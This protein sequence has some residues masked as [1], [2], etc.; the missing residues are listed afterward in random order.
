MKKLVILSLLLTVVIRLN[1]Q[2]LGIEEQSV[3]PYKQITRKKTEPT[4]PLNESSS[5]IGD[6][7]NID[8]LP[9]N[10]DNIKED[11]EPVLETIRELAGSASAQTSADQTTVESSEST[12]PPPEIIPEVSAP[13]AEQAQSEERSPD[14]P[15]LELE[16]KFHR[17]YNRYNKKPTSADAWA[18]ATAKQT[19]QEYVV[20]KGDTLWTISNVLFGDSLFWPK[21]WAINKQGILN[22][23]FIYPGTKIYFY[24]GDEQTAPSLSVGQKEESHEIEK[25][26]E[27]SV[28][29]KVEIK[30]TTDGT[31]VH[32][33]GGSELVPRSVIPDSLPLYRNAE[34]F[35]PEVKTDVKLDLPVTPKYDFTPESEIFITNKPVGTEVEIQLSETTKYRCY[36]GR[37]LRDIRFMG[38]LLEDYDVFEPLGSFRT[39]IGSM[40]AYK[41]YGSARLYD[42][43]KLKLYDCKSILATSLI[44]IPK[45]K[46]ATLKNTK[47][48]ITRKARV[49]GGP[50]VKS[51]RLFV[52][53]QYAYVDFGSSEYSPGQEYETISQMTDKING[54][55]T[56]VSKYGSFAVVMITNVD[57]L[58]EIGDKVVVK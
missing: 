57:D 20:Q 11:E 39:T 21:L 41:K 24:M 30:E 40:Y 10:R 27:T 29:E 25:I 32:T 51:Q 5:L 56:V 45:E 36:E 1:A 15:D 53:G 3:K 58:I 22:P 9:A 26:D 4:E 14:D 33:L 50:D 7:D 49:I 12:P 44:L 54:N 31:I 48:S 16:R 2:E 47:Q 13:V 34:Y 37:I 17:I 8:P 6:P 55:F 46:I 19:V 42:N 35:N 52:P 38:K 28:G 18:A 43:K 23:H